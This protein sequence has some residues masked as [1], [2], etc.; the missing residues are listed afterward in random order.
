MLT[1][2]VHYKVL[3]NET[4]LQLQPQVFLRTYE[5][6]A[7]LAIKRLNIKVVKR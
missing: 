4:S 5:L 2:G 6:F 1:S 7:A 3:R